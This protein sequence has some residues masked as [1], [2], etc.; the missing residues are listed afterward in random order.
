MRIPFSF[1]KLIP[2]FIFVLFILSSCTDP[3]RKAI[4]LKLEGIDLSYKSEFGK[5]IETLQKSLEYDDKDPETYFYIGTSYYGLNQKDSAFAYYTRA[6][7]VDPKYGQAYVNRGR[8]YKDRN[9]R[10]NACRDWLKA[11]ECGI[12]SIKEETKFCK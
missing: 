1:S 8:M 5:A 2:A 12:K 6:I 9:D 10:D 7:T 3:K 11:E 4:D